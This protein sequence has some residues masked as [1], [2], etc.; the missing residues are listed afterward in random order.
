MAGGGG[1]AGGVGSGKAGGRGE[2]RLGVRAA[3][4]KLHPH[5]LLDSQQCPPPRAV[6]R[7]LSLFQDPARPHCSILQ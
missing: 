7:I 3:G 4:T 1:E 5:S 2:Q 6:P